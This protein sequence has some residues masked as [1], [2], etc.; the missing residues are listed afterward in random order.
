MFALAIPPIIPSLP[1]K[2]TLRSFLSPSSFP[3][4]F[5]NSLLYSSIVPLSSIF[6]PQSAE[7]E[8]ILASILLEEN[9]KQIESDKIYDDIVFGFGCK[10][11]FSN[12][13]EVVP[14]FLPSHSFLLVTSSHSFL[15]LTPLSRFSPV[16]F[17]SFPSLFSS[18]SLLFFFYS[19]SASVE[20][21]RGGGGG[22][23]FLF[24]PF[25]SA[26]MPFLPFPFPFSI[27]IFILPPFLP[28]FMV[29]RDENGRMTHEIAK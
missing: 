11:A 25:P 21:T 3:F 7:E 10:S 12:S 29:F 8:G 13:I 16:F 26:A 18:P 28:S 17:S 2:M 5:P 19:F 23:P 6:Y 22:F 20:K 1:L 27:S 14:S 15:L 4:P 24:L 9:G